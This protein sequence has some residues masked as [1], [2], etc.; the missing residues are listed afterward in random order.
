M[1]FL[2]KEP[3]I[4]NLNSIL[5][6]QRFFHDAIS[7]ISK[8]EERLTMKAPKIIDESYSMTL[9][10]KD[11]LT[12]LKEFV[13][14]LDFESEQQ[15]IEFFKNI[16]PQI[17]GKLIFYNK[18]YRMEISCPVPNGQLLNTFLHN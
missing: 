11:L 4:L 8:K 16:K 13:L 6:K 2:N 18:V 17:L 10:L 5:M 1:Y 7:K 15:E 9:L 3:L 14:N 12:E